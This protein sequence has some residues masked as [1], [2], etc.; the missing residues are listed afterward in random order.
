MDQDRSEFLIEI[1]ELIEKVFADL[2]QLRENS[3]NPN[4]RRQS[5]DPL[6]R[7]V[8]SVKGLSAAIGLETVSQIAHE[9]ET[10]LDAV[11]LGRVAVDERVLDR[12]LKTRWTHCPKVWASLQAA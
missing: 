12:R 7:H 6:F 10:L 3:S 9:F 4:S 1:E 2:D 5:I 11:R 8:H